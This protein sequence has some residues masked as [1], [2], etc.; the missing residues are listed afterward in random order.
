M[1]SIAK[2]L[3]SEFALMQPDDNGIMSYE[4]SIKLATRKSKG[5]AKP[6]KDGAADTK[7]PATTRTTRKKTTS[8]D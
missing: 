3:P 7:K 1:D 6:A 8:K 4:K 2:S 5:A